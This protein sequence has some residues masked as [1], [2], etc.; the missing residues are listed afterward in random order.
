MIDVYQ[1]SGQRAAREWANMHRRIAAFTNAVLL[2]LIE[3]HEV[4]EPGRLPAGDKAG[5]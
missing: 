2:A 5:A 4:A 3:A 1:A